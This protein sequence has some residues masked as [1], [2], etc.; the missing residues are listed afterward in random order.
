M[1]HI[2]SGFV[3]Q[4]SKRRWVGE[5]E[6]YGYRFTVSAQSGKA[7]Q[8]IALKKANLLKGVK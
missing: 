6:V 2:G 3:L 4:L 1:N 5:F 8:A 7:V